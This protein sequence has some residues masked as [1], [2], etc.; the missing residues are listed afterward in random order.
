MAFRKERISEEMATQR[1]ESLCVR[2]EHCR[3]ELEEKLR[4]WG[5]V[6]EERDKILDSL[7]ERRF[8]DDRRFAAAFVRDK[9]LY[10]RWGKMKIRIAL[11]AKRIDRSLVEEALEDIDEEAYRE[12]ARSFLTAKARTVREGNT[13]EGRTKLYRAGLS[14]GFESSLVASIV[15]DPATWGVENDCM[16]E[17]EDD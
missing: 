17:E 3:Y 7:E 11:S 6:T 9:M 16:R 10:N 2:G 15:K 12:S 5:F 1:L 4:R 8:F 14:R 13:Y